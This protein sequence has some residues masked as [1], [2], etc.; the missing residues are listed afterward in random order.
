VPHTPAGA[1]MEA[2][3]LAAAIERSEAQMRA[4]LAARPAQ[5]Q[6]L[7]E[8]M[9]ES[10]A[11]SGCS[12]AKLL[13]R[14]EGR[15]RWR[16]EV[17][18]LDQES[19]RYARELARLLAQRRT[20]QRQAASYVRMRRLLGLWHAFHVPLGMTLFAAAFLHIVGALY[21]R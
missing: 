17:A 5:L 3:Q 11:T 7:V 9:G 8:R 16:R 2:A 10:P 6:T 20:L 13:A 19:R 14:W 4:W 15:R 12:P 21:Y 18:R 1:T